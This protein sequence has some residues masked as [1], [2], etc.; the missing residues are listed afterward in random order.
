MLRHR[1]VGART[2]CG[3]I[4]WWLA[5]GVA[6]AGVGLIGGNVTVEAATISFEMNS[7]D[8]A[9][10]FYFDNQGTDDLTDDTLSAGVAHVDFTLK[11]SGGTEQYLGAAFE[12]DSVL[13]SAL[14]GSLASTTIY[15]LLFDGSFS[16]KEA[17]TDDLILSATFDDTRMLLLEFAGSGIVG[18]ASGLASDGVANFSLGPAAPA[19]L[20]VVG[21]EAFQFTMSNLKS[22][23]GGLVHIS[24]VPAPDNFQLENFTFSN[25]FSGSMALIP[26]PA[27]IGLAVSGL[28]GLMVVGWRRSRA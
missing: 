8:V 22:E 5:C 26:E 16:F 17:G 15:Q 20:A 12:F 10:L 11:H 27:T 21:D 28:L 7:V 24:S 3:P 23:T 1:Q 2:G 4:A 13:D 18:F 25:S 14:S 9:P 19:G 6:L